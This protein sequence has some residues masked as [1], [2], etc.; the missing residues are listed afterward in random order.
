M[1]LSPKPYSIP[2]ISL[3]TL[4]TANIN[5]SFNPR[6]TVA[7]I[8]MGQV[9]LVEEV[10]LRIQCDPVSPTPPFNTKSLTIKSGSAAVYDSYHSPQWQVV[11]TRV[12]GNGDSLD[13]QLRSPSHSRLPTNF[14]SVN[15]IYH[16]RHLASVLL[17]ESAYSNWGELKLSLPVEKAL[18]GERYEFDIILS[19]QHQPTESP[20]LAPLLSSPS[21]LSS[22]SPSSKSLKYKS[23][24]KGKDLP[25]S[26]SPLSRLDPTLVMMK[27]FL[28]D[29]QSVDVQFLFETEPAPSG[30]VPSLWAHRL[31]LSRYPALNALVRSAESCKV[32]LSMRPDM[33]VL[34]QVDLDSTYVM[35]ECAQSNTDAVM[36]NGLYLDDTMSSCEH[37]CK[38][39]FDRGVEDAE[40]FWPVKGV[41]CRD[42]HSAAKHFGITDLQEI[43]LEGMVESIDASNVVE[44]LFEFGGSSAMA[45]E[46][47]LSF[48]NENLSILFAEGRDPFLGYREREECYV[49]MVKVMRS[50]AN[51]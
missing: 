1:R 11:L 13:I 22:S 14:R 21:L 10:T 45:R 33:F 49:I 25:L 3:S 23:T 38:T 42:L 50:L 40:S 7:P 28:R 41:P 20:K 36:V 35:R 48:M 18:N 29:R 31:V 19:T 27:M 43:C 16:Q 12:G 17:N 8:N 37:N 39:I 51:R 30:R 44:M 26:S 9:D 15:V 32:Q 6:T 47:G 46:A 4:A 2:P 34:N 5:I 24:M